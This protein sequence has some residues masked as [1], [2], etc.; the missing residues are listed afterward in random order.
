MLL[1]CSLKYVSGSVQRLFTV[2]S[3]CV[4]VKLYCY[5]LIVVVKFLWVSGTCMA[6][7][8]SEC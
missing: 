5:L 2:A 1:G 8:R 3:E 6:S 4:Y 7:S